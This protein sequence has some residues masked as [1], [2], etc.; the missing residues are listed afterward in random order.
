VKCE[1]CALGESF[2]ENELEKKFK[3]NEYDVVVITE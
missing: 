1:T 2:K 3:L